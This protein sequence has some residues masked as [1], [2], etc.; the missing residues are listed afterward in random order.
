M[1]FEMGGTH[2]REFNKMKQDEELVTDKRHYNTSDTSA[3][4]NLS[5][6]MIA[7]TSQASEAHILVPADGKFATAVDKG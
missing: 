7:G 1:L 3:H 5:K 6:N 2:E 4:R